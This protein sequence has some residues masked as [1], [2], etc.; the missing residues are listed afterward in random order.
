MPSTSSLV[1]STYFLFGCRHTATAVPRS[2]CAPVGQEEDHP[3]DVQQG[4]DAIAGACVT[5]QLT[6]KR[7]TMRCEEPLTLEPA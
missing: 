4:D 3:H 5:Q 6:G 2:A 7:H 1:L